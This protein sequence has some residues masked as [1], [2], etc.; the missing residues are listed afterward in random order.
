MLEREEP[1]QTKNAAEWLGMLLVM[2]VALG[3]RLYGIHGESAWYDETVSLRFLDAPSLFDFLKSERALDPPMM[4][5]YFAIQYGWGRLFGTDVA[6]VRLLSVLFSVCTVPMVYLIGRRLFGRVAGFAGAI[7]QTFSMSNLLYAQEVRVYSL[8]VF[9]VVCSAYALVRALESSG[10]RWWWVHILF[11]ALLMSTHMFAV[12]FVAA[13]APFLFILYFGSRYGSSFRVSGRCLLFWMVAHAILMVLW[14]GWLATIDFSALHSAAQWISKPSFEQLESIYYVLAGV[15]IQVPTFREYRGSALSAG[16]QWHLDSILA[17][18]LLGSTLLFLIRVAATA[19]LGRSSAACQ[20]C[21]PSNTPDAR[22]SGNGAGGRTEADIP[23]SSIF[24]LGWAVTPV[25]ALLVA[26]IVRQPSLVDRYVLYVSPALYILFG[27]AVW[28]VGVPAR[29]TG[30]N[31]AR[32]TVQF[33]TIAV[34]VAGYSTL[35]VT[36][37]KPWRADWQ[38]VVEH[39]RK[40]SVGADIIV[41]AGSVEKHALMFNAPDM[42][43]RIC[44]KRLE[45]LPK[46]DFWV[47][48]VYASSFE[49][50]AADRY[51]TSVYGSNYVPYEIPALD[52]ALFLHVHND[53][54][55]KKMPKNI[56]WRKKQ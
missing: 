55:R 14:G 36:L 27:A 43:D 9:L 31:A 20:P 21:S 39:I 50:R 25:L 54:N 28:S 26:S 30:S 29:G 23:W 32:R 56:A 19:L 3:L 46:G 45:Y 22:D 13:V 52:G 42:V 8:V 47:G 34:V 15:W 4:P 12:L 2:A 17:V 41:P 1:G 35:F 49:N 51:L 33:L 5:L 10:W 16:C 7:C 24:L 44:E 11:D 38:T 37:P 6:T 40:D 48:P 18:M 53:A